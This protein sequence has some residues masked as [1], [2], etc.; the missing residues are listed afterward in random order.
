MPS[1]TS[2][3]P[4][5]PHPAALSPPPSPQPACP[6]LSPAGGFGRLATGARRRICQGVQL[7]RPPAAC[8]LP[9][10]PLRRPLPL[11]WARQQ[12]SACRWGRGGTEAKISRCIPG[13]SGAGVCLKRA[14]AFLRLLP[15]AGAA[16]AVYPLAAAGP[17]S[18][19]WGANGTVI[20]LHP[21]LPHAPDSMRNSFCCVGAGVRMVWMEGGVD[22]TGGKVRRPW[23]PHPREM[24]TAE[25]NGAG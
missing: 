12:S 8:A 3:D 24:P 22:R 9:G 1:R 19:R 2:P 23:R 13:G 11:R 5:S 25:K 18:P 20:G 6:P 14:G 17:P 7:T 10:M 4:A 15:V 16:P 21:P